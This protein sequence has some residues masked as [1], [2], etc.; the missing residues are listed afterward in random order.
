[1]N[2]YDCN[3]M[4]FYYCNIKPFQVHYKYKCI[5]ELLSVGFQIKSKFYL[6]TDSSIV[7]FED[8]GVTI[9]IV[10]KFVRSKSA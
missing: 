8:A 1:M 2:F 3:I 4:R 6:G 9:R 5:E 7:F 10:R